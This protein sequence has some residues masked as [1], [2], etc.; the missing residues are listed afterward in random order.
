MTKYVFIYHA[1]MTPAEAT[2][3]TPEQMEAVMAEWNA[4]AGQVG[5]GLVDFG[6]PL[7]GGVRVTADGTSP[8]T[9]E[10]AGYSIIEADDLDAALELAKNHPHLKHAG[11]LRDRGPRGAADPRHVSSARREAS[12]VTSVPPVSLYPDAY[13]AALR[14]A[15][16][17]DPANITAVPSSTT[18]PSW[19]RI[20]VPSVVT[21][22]LLPQTPVT[23]TSAVISS[24]WAD[25]REEPPRHLERTAPGLGS[26]C[27]IIR[28]VQQ[29]RRDAALD[30]QPTETEGRGDLLVER[31]GLRSPLISVKS[32]TSRWRRRRVTSVHDGADLGTGHDASMPTATSS[33]LPATGRPAEGA[34]ARSWVIDTRPRSTPMHSH[35]SLDAARAFEAEI[36]RRGNQP[37]RRFAQELQRQRRSRRSRRSR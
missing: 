36:R 14:D 35:L 18:T 27:A 21:G 32:S 19:F 4:W 2:P 34:A 22:L 6:T 12:T 37:E 28:R 15:H 20:R 23:V 25:R 9:R 3:P 24:P 16:L 33:G 1:P 29:S 10:V 31:I 5:D 17:R 13:P 7:A 30:H 26:C 11:R 8:S